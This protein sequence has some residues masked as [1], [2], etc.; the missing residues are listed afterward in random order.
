MNL[1]LFE[2]KNKQTVP[3]TTFR[4]ATIN[5]HLFNDPVT[6]DRNVDKLAKLLEPYQLDL[7]AV[8]EISQNNCWKEF[9]NLLQL[10]H[11]RFGE[12][13]GNYIGN[14]FACR[15]PIR[16]YSNQYTTYHCENERRGFLQC[17]FDDT[18]NSFLHNRT[19]AVTHLDHLNENNR[20]RQ[21]KEFDPFNK[22]IDILLGDMN[23]LTENDYSNEYFQENIYQLRKKSDW[24]RPL[25]DL[26]KHLT[27][28]WNYQD[29]FRLK[30]PSLIDR[31]IVTSRFHTR[32]DYIYLKPKENDSWILDECFIIDTNNITDHK[33]VFASFRKIL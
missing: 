29:A 11:Y 3:M 8:Q 23:S 13:S 2:I 33:A 10:P 28:N 4:L 6:Y 17:I 18:N 32:I 25:F 31:D 7:I 16:E 21:M 14:G 27:Q 15:Y 5:A 30:N 19:F 22:N 24:E 26:T 12:A 1:F 9:C 20:L